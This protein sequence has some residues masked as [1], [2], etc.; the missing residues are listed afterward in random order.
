[1]ATQQQTQGQSAPR[2]LMAKLLEIQKSVEVFSNSED[3]D[4]K[5]AKGQS[6]YKYT[7][8]WVILEAVR[9][10]MNELGL[11]LIQDVLDESHTMIDYPVFKSINGTI[12]SF[13]KREMYSTVKVSYTWHDTQTG[14]TF[15][16][17]TMPGAGANGTDKSL[18][19]ALAL[20]ERYFLLKTFHIPTRD[21]DDEP[22][23]HDSGNIPGIP[24]GQQ[25]LAATDRQVASA[26]GQAPV[27]Q[28]QQQPAQAAPAAQRPVSGDRVNPYA[29][30]QGYKPQGG[31]PFDPNDPLIA[32]TAGSLSHF[33][34]GTPSHQQTLNASAQ[35]LAA[36]G[37][38]VQDPDFMVNLTE[39]GQAMREGRQP[40]Y[41]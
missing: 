30:P 10:K 6:E 27:P 22:D 31:R 34:A 38:N 17:V 36:N 33:Q 7:P 41:Q 18:A 21:K 19:S 40:M 14:E 4:K 23:A 28:A 15:G 32:R 1:M 13:N 2:G 9:K 5:N 11:L 24:A 8:G 35:A 3:S 39:M 37:F 20:S 26:S 25:P 16:P 12:M 29:A